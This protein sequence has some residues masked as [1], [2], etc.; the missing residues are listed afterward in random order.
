MLH[1]L[2]EKICVQFKYR[3]IPII[4]APIIF[5]FSSPKGPLLSGGRYFRVA[6]TF[7]W[8]ENVCNS[9]VVFSLS[10]ANSRKLSI[11][12]QQKPWPEIPI[13]SW[14]EQL[15]LVR[16]GSF[17]PNGQGKPG[18]TFL[19]VYEIPLFAPLWNVGLSCQLQGNAITKLISAGW[20]TIQLAI[21]AMWNKY[22]FTT[23]ID[24]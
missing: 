13:S 8:L 11:A 9:A 15:L 6:V 20:K 24:D 19:V 2:F 4:T 10:T 1:S 5:G 18:K 22:G 14:Q 17:L 7:G 3:R 16:E 12:W 21:P 23:K